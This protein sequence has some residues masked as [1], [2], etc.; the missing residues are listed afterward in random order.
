MA[1][2]EAAV[3]SAI[4]RKNLFNAATALDGKRV[5]LTDG[6]LQDVTGYF[7]SDYIAV[8][9]GQAYTLTTGQFMGL[10]D[11]DKVF[12]SS[13][14]PNLFP[15]TLTVPTGVAFIRASGQKAI[16]TAD[17]F[18][19]QKGTGLTANYIPWS[20]VIDA[21]KTMPNTLPGDSLQDQ[22][23]SA[24]KARFLQLGKN[25]FDKDAAVTGHLINS[26][27]GQLQAATGW[28]ASDFIPVT[29]G[30]SYSLTRGNYIAFYG[31]GQAIL[32][33]GSNPNANAYTVTAPTGA[34]FMRCSLLLAQVSADAF[35]V[36]AGSAVTAYEPFGY[37]L[38]PT[39]QP[40]GPSAWRGKS[41]G[42]MGD[43]TTV[44]FRWQ[45]YVTLRHGLAYSGFG[46]A[47][48]RISGSAADAMWQDAR[49]NALPTTLDLVTVLGGVNDWNQN[50]ALGAETSTTTTEFNGGLNVMIGK[51]LARFPA[52]RVVLSTPTYA[53]KSDW[54][55][56]G[57]S[58]AYTNLAGLTPNDYAEAVR[59]AGRRWNLPVIDLMQD[60]GWG[61]ANILDYMQNSTDLIHFFGLG[62]RRVGE[63]YNGAL[64]ELQPV[65]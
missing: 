13:D 57:W 56:A 59:N 45:P 7:A 31:A 16:V 25:L 30:Q 34:V 12:V 36:E 14:N 46:V 54:V 61:N 41:W 19:V 29:A 51:L 20:R 9:A 42:A 24:S 48:T 10:Y 53:Q 4:Y 49:V 58:N 37:T 17:V 65:G 11:A 22:S 5:Q 38:S 6:T 40:G 8:E 3:N 62:A 50:A 28:T 43:S 55:A 39:S 15:Y 60:C 18:M 27:T 63:V 2:D 21:S 23:I 35:Q 1:I 52:R 47:G 32:G 26:T 33:T 44:Q 64:A